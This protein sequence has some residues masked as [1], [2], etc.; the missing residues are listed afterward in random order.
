MIFFLFIEA[1]DVIIY[2]YLLYKYLHLR[3]THIAFDLHVT[4][5]S[6]YSSTRS[7]SYLCVTIVYAL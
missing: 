1:F 2:S 5:H 6:Y 4:F 3:E 7:S